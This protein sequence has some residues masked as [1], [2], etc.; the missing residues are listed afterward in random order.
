MNTNMEKV[1]IPRAEHSIS[2]S[3]LSPNGVKVLYKL[4]EHGFIAYLVGGGVRDL[5]LGREPKDFDVVTDATPNQLKK[6]FR[7]CRLIGRRFRL[8]HIHFHDEII[9]VATFRSTVDAAEASLEEAAEAL[10]EEL[11]EA[12]PEAEQLEEERDRRRRRHHHGPPILKSED[13]M[14]LRDNVF[15]T[16]EE[17][18]VRR[19]FTVNALFYNIADFSIIDHVGGMEDLKNGLI[20]TIGDPMV[21]FTEDPVRMIRAIRFASMLGFNIEAR[22]EAAIEALCGTINKATPPR[23][24]EEVLK[25]LLMGAGERTY[26]M[27]RHCG[28]FEPLFPHF[29]AWLSRE[30]DCYPHVRVGK[31][32]EWADSQIG[33]GIAVTP[34]LL[35]ALMFGEYLE[36]KVAQFRDEG[37]PPQQATD[38]AVA[39][40][41]GEL[42]PTVSV[43]NRVLVAVRDILNMQH[44]FQKTPGRNGRG[45][46]G[47]PVFPDALQYLRFMEQ[48]TPP[49]RSLAEWWER[50]A[51]QQAEGLEPAPQRGNE[52]AAADAEAPKKKRRRRRRRKKPGG[53]P[54]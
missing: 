16:P 36:E 14:V 25:L 5:L 35:I 6:L 9:E 22:T 54:E 26:Q 40:F 12:P 19:D 17:D 15:G 23:L 4:R 41:A 44:R 37:L 29:D 34:P 39:A 2:R 24:Y 21:R 50:Y 27:M 48:L 3:V 47:R 49:K 28:L 30:S 10:P 33:Q 42:A 8:A 43:P 18:A 45:V 20:R 53:A 11:V 52:A 38:A 13:G 31:A 7:N 51:V 1:I 32:L 46:L